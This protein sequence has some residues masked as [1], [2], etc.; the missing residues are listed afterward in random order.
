MSVESITDEFKNL[1]KEPTNEIS[2][3]F[4]NIHTES[5]KNY[6][7]QESD[8]SENDSGLGLD[9]NEDNEM[10]EIESPESVDNEENK[11]DFWKSYGCDEIP[12]IFNGIPIKEDGS[13][14]YGGYNQPSLD[15]NGQIYWPKSVVKYVGLEN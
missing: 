3:D 15:K 1:E 11:E 12:E 4:T 14:V 5:Q 10:D 9:P 6:F 7:D 13:I 8:Q 2:E